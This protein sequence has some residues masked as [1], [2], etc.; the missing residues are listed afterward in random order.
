MYRIAFVNTQVGNVLVNDNLGGEG[1]TELDRHANMCV[2]GKHCYLLSELET[3]QTVSVGAFSD[4]ARGLNNVPIV[5]A[6]LAYDCE[7]MN[8]V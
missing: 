5:D 8:Q 3:A 2:L 1:Y 4:S 6:M 7:R